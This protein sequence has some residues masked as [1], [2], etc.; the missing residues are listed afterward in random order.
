MVDR[1]LTP[2]TCVSRMAPRLTAPPCT[3]LALT[4]LMGSPLRRLPALTQ[5]SAMRAAAVSAAHKI[6]TPPMGRLIFNT[7]PAVYKDKVNTLAR[8][9]QIFPRGNR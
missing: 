1:N 6:P 2:P 4:I 9:G 5:Q 8:T 7:F 3:R